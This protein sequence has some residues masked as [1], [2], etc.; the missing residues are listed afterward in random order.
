VYNF[1]NTTRV[2]VGPC[3]RKLELLEDGDPR[4]AVLE[5]KEFNNPELLVGESSVDDSTWWGEINM[6]T[7]SGKKLYHTL[8]YLNKSVWLIVDLHT[9][10]WL[11]ERPD[12]SVALFS[13]LRTDKFKAFA[14]GGGGNVPLLFMPPWTL[15]EAQRCAYGLKNEIQLKN[16]EDVKQRF[17]MFGG[18]A[19]FLFASDLKVAIQTLDVA[20]GEVKVESLMDALNPQGKDPSLSSILVHMYPSDD[21][22]H[23][24]ETRFASEE[25]RDRLLEKLVSH[26]AFTE[27]VW[28]KST[29]DIGNA[30]GKAYR[31]EQLWHYWAQHGSRD[32]T[33]KYLG[34]GCDK[35]GQRCDKNKITEPFDTRLCFVN[36]RNTLRIRNLNDLVEFFEG[37]YV[38]PSVVNFPTVDSFAFYQGHVWDADWGVPMKNNITLVLWQMTITKDNRHSAQAPKLVSI[39]EKCAKFLPNEFNVVFLY[40][41]EDVS[42]F[43][44]QPYVTKERVA[45][46]QM[47]KDL[48]TR[49][50]EIH[51]YAI[52]FKSEN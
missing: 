32:I 38:K 21:F 40:A 47:P 23:I 5:L 28:I 15:D 30:G 29:D 12:C 7:H 49:V 17:D 31:F 35:T 43:E 51:Q 16:E 25:I 18:S 20:L 33:I 48:R 46:K 8:K 22:I 52:K 50:G 6:D 37:Q 2:V 27:E 19:R 4:K 42:G 9:Q 24:K 1:H 3:R 45:Y 10:D 39:I 44:F 36:K 26:T 41:V 14:R 34:G 13:S 11:D